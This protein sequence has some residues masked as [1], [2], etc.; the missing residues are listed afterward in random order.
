[1]SRQVAIVVLAWNQ[2][3]LTLDCLSS[4]RKLDYSD[5]RIVVVDNASSDG[6]AEA[7]RREYPEATVIENGENLGYARGNNVGV[8]YA[9]E[10]GAQYVLVL[11]NDTVV[12]PTMLSE[13]VNVMETTP[14]AGIVGP[15]MYC[16]EPMTTLFAAGS[17]VDWHNGK[18]IHRG[19]FQPEDAF[20]SRGVPESVDFICGCG[21]LGNRRV[22]KELGGF[23]ASYY[24]NFEDVEFAMRVREMG[25]GVRYTP[26]ATLWH[27]VSATLGQGSP[28]NTYYMT[29]NALL[30]FWTNSPP[31]LR[32]LSTYK[33]LKRAIRTSIAWRIRSRYQTPEYGV[34][35]K[36]NAL[37]I[38][39]FFLGRFGE[40]GPDVAVACGLN[41][42]GR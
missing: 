17:F 29:R 19:L 20:A 24:L 4:L 40:M 10:M 3:N 34:K 7:V 33:I 28:A 26:R 2:R 1:M 16:N 25:L 30:F 41:G 12:A 22:F 14:N 38:R 18:L 11:N 42:A 13:L 21:L 15:M 23:N 35:Q 32:F 39:D 31:G 27:R 6:T 36:A 9:L 8:D 5:R 37:G